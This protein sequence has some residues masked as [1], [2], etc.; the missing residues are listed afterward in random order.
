VCTT[1]PGQKKE[2]KRKERKKKRKEKEKEKGK[3][4]VSLVLSRFR[5]L[6][7]NFE[8]P[9]LGSCPWTC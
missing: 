1:T 3:K 5:W 7:R 4:I 8:D 9:L 6:S 2:K